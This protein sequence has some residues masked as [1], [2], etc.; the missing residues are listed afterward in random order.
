MM[1]VV[2]ATD[3]CFLRL[4][5]LFRNFSFFQLQFLFLKSLSFWI[6]FF[7]TLVCNNHHFFCVSVGRLLLNYRVSV[8]AADHG[9]FFDKFHINNDE[10]P[11]TI[12]HRR[13]DY[14]VRINDEVFCIEVQTSKIFANRRLVAQLNAFARAGHQ[15]ILVVPSTHLESVRTALKWADCPYP[16]A[17]FDLR[18]LASWLR[19]MKIDH[20]E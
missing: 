8:L 18:E 20:N 17:I 19:T 7:S 13:P 16:Y 14:I 6:V 15:T 5:T 9:L 1:A 2:V 10:H 12:L 3:C 4:T 11:L